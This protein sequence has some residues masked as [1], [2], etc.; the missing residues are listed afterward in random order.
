[1]E[2]KSIGKEL[3]AKLYHSEWWKSCTQREIVVFQLFTKEYCCPID[4]F[5]NA[6]RDVL[7]VSVLNSR[8]DENR[9]RVGTMVNA[10][11]AEYYQIMLN[12]VKKLGA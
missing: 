12:I 10:T 3:G 8:W 11:E 2:I 6:I 4:L 9:S 5:G 7:G 1:M